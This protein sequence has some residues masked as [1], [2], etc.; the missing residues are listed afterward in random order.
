MDRTKRGEGGSSMTLKYDNLFYCVKGGKLGH[1]IRHE[2]ALI[3]NGTAYCP[4]HKGKRLRIHPQH[5][6]KNRAFQRV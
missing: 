1:W 4:E 5:P 3:R 6:K 2:N